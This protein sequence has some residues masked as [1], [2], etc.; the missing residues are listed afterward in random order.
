MRRADPALNLV[1]NLALAGAGFAMLVRPRHISA[2][3]HS[4]LLP[5]TF[6]LTRWVACTLGHRVAASRPVE[7][8]PR[9][10]RLIARLAPSSTVT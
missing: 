5:A 3:A 9:L 10:P 7:R 6:R 8:A 1:V 4:P 2:V